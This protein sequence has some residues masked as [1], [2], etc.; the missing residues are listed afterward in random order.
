MTGYDDPDLVA[1]L[2]ELAD[3]VR[4]LP[5]IEDHM[6]AEGASASGF[7]FDQ[8]RASRDGI[9]D[10][11]ANRAKSMNIKPGSLRLCVEIANHHRD[12]TRKRIPLAQLRRDLGVAINVLRSQKQES[13]A[14]LAI[15]MHR[16]ATA[17]ASA[18]S[19]DAA[20]SYLEACRG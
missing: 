20:E 2:D 3:M 4:R 11:I 5:V 16:Q 8:L 6:S 10:R 15:A 7:R 18:D 9:L 17:T 19:A 14:L 1:A 13:D 12:R